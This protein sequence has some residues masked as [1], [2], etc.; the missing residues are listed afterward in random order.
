MSA[1]RHMEWRVFYFRKLNLPRRFSFQFSSVLFMAVNHPKKQIPPAWLIQ[2]GPVLSRQLV[3]WF[4]KFRAK[5]ISCFELVS[6]YLIFFSWS[7]RGSLWCGGKSPHVWSHIGN[8][9]LKPSSVLV[10]DLGVCQRHA[11]RDVLGYM[12]GY[13][14]RGVS[15]KVNRALHY[16]ITHPDCLLL[17]FTMPS[18]YEILCLQ[19]QGRRV[20]TLFESISDLSSYHEGKDP[21]TFVIHDLVHA[22][23]F[24]CQND[25]HAQQVVF[26]QKVKSE[27][28]RGVYDRLLA[29]KPQFK[30]E[31][32]YLIADMNSHPAHLE[33]TLQALVRLWS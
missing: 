27:I 15:C 13:L 7:Y 10:G 3:P 1:T 26:Y 20:V 2:Q 8:Q 25:S 14:L 32:E 33:A 30:T 4:E 16:W 22:D 9:P 12:A 31:F 6:I 28:D 11:Q 19:A 18:P 17:T 23:E 5:E 29:S 24:F 21:L